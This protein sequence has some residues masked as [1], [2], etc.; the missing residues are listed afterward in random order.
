MGPKSLSMTQKNI[1]SR[2]RYQKAKLLK[3][4]RSLSE[5]SKADVTSDSDIH[6]KEN[7]LAKCNDIE[8]NIFL[9]GL[10]LKKNKV[11]LI[12]NEDL[13]ALSSNEERLTPTKIAKRKLPAF[14][15]LAA[16]SS[17]V[18]TSDDDFP[19]K[20]R[21]GRPSL[22]DSD[23]TSASDRGKQPK[24][25]SGRKSAPGSLNMKDMQVKEAV[26]LSPKRSLRRSDYS[27]KEVVSDISAKKS[28]K[29]D[30]VKE[31]TAVMQETRE[32]VINP[33]KPKSKPKRSH[34]RLSKKRKKAKAKNSTQNML[35][36]T[37]YVLEERLH[38]QKEE[39]TKFSSRS[40]SFLSTDTDNT[41]ISS[42]RRSSR[43]CLQRNEL[44]HTDPKSLPN[45]CRNP[46]SRPSCDYS[47]AN[48]RESSVPNKNDVL[49]ESDGKLPISSNRVQASSITKSPK[50]S[51][52]KELLRHSCVLSKCTTGQ[53]MIL[54]I[55]VKKSN[56]NNNYSVNIT[57][58][59]QVN[60]KRKK[61][62]SEKIPEV[63][64][65][66]NSS[67]DNGTLLNF[68]K[69]NPSF[70]KCNFNAVVDLNKVDQL[71][72]AQESEFLD[73]STVQEDLIRS[74]DNLKFLE[75]FERIP[76]DEL[77]NYKVEEPEIYKPP[78]DDFDFSSVSNLRVENVRSLAVEPTGKGKKI[79]LNRNFDDLNPLPTK[80]RRNKFKFILDDQFEKLT[81]RCDMFA[82]ATLAEKGV[83]SGMQKNSVL[84]TASEKTQ[85][86]VISP[87]EATAQL[88]HEVQKELLKTVP[89]INHVKKKKLVV[90]EHD[91]EGRKS[92]ELKKTLH[93]K[94]SDV[95]EDVMKVESPKNAGHTDQDNKHKTM[96]KKTVKSKDFSTNRFSN[97]DL[98]EKKNSDLEENVSNTEETSTPKKNTSKKHHSLEA[99]EKPVDE[100]SS[101]KKQYSSREILTRSRSPKKQAKPAQNTFDNY[102]EIDHLNADSM[103]PN[104]DNKDH[105]TTCS[106]FPEK[107]INNRRKIKDNKLSGEDTDHSVEKKQQDTT[108]LE[109]RMK[110]E[111]SLSEKITED[112]S[113]K[114]THL[115]KKKQKYSKPTEN[116]RRS[117]EDVCLQSP[118]T[119]NT[120]KIQN[121]V[122]K[123]LKSPDKIVN[124]SLDNSLQS[125]HCVE[126]VTNNQKLLH[127][128]E[129]K[130]KS[131]EIENRGK[132]L[133]SDEDASHGFGTIKE[134]DVVDKTISRE[135][136]EEKSSDDSL[137]QKNSFS[138]QSR[139]HKPLEKLSKAYDEKPNE[140]E[141]V[142]P[143]YNKKING[144]ELRENTKN[145][146]D[147]QGNQGT[148]KIIKSPNK[149][150]SRRDLNDQ[151]TLI[152][153]MKQ[154]IISPGKKINLIRP[155][156]Q[157]RLLLRR[158]LFETVQ[159]EENNSKNISFSKLDNALENI[160]KTS[161]NN[162]ISLNSQLN[163]YPITKSPASD[164]I[165]K[166]ENDVPTRLEPKILP[167]IPIT[168]KLENDVS[169]ILKPEDL[170]SKIIASKKEKSIEVQ[171]NNTEQIDADSAQA[172]K[173]QPS[174]R[175]L[176][177]IVNN[178]GP[179][180]SGFGARTFNNCDNMSYLKDES[181]KS[182]INPSNDRH[183][184][185]F[186][187]HNQIKRPPKMR[188]GPA[189][190]VM[191]PCNVR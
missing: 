114:H 37:D 139:K 43:R 74:E 111:Q 157:E 60:Q 62:T 16:V 15:K 143:S 20:R 186:M 89:A 77:M 166:L 132:L 17:D 151:S 112:I 129:N 78:L 6:T 19:R 56:E 188:L 173:V 83:P 63:K 158:K 105:L 61:R 34:R 180:T 71:H 119:K 66:I 46:Y 65:R 42:E 47:N 183:K 35:K 106:K 48:K 11:Y 82:G 127:V 149:N 122:G 148:E 146:E 80:P 147:V 162:V 178:D 9:K 26:S 75:G 22:L 31:A 138:N 117:D 154:E 176:K 54:N 3:A 1:R 189:V 124:E 84:E 168:V 160:N 24:I 104:S 123:R 41:N 73:E 94:S 50:K 171:K 76:E 109:N 64:Y 8:E 145:I 51:P 23:N 108:S 113:K 10:S 126:K 29:T 191:R 58:N 116:R 91:K 96:V 175:G 7:T 156:V 45:I 40:S 100:S 87:V 107:S 69:N 121:N 86:L 182:D 101:T 30:L 135:K 184:F 28:L 12:S 99:K 155:V 153:K 152:R 38:P 179:S 53:P 39:V 110:V 67:K 185:K 14:S 134:H 167:N 68:V 81:S 190:N 128:E 36:L 164:L 125:K 79:K 102:R 136:I 90:V 57:D 103:D 181:L 32:L 115:E 72:A 133:H 140:E 150:R 169:S 144:S 170:R 93:E 25:I 177:I 92:D 163:K 159:L 70:S 5:S 161:T 4:S 52:K 21:R 165:V 141:K 174:E 142:H 2:E 131:S 172:R 33:L 98:S 59:I 137:N 97:C 49:S 88:M 44:K 85:H 13:S 95:Y 55:N 18:T 187:D 118:Q 27:S 120:I 130:L